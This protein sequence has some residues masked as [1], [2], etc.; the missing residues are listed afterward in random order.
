[1]IKTFATA[2]LSAAVFAAS[3]TFDYKMNGDDW[4]KIEV[5]GKFPNELCDTGK[6][7][8]PIDLTDAKWSSTQK[9]VLNDQYTDNAKKTVIE[10]HTVKTTVGEGQFKKIFEDESSLLFNAA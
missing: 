9:I 2:L 1:M 10:A 7:Q 3:G 5:D 6:Q 8:S 4:G